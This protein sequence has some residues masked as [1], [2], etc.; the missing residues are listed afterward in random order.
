[1]DEAIRHLTSGQT[2]ERTCSFSNKMRNNCGY[3]ILNL[4]VGGSSL[5]ATLQSY[6]RGQRAIPGAGFSR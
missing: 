5:W 6:V 4:P 3:G 1:M 2:R